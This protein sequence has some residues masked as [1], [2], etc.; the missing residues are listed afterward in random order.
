MTIM[1]EAGRCATIAGAHCLLMIPDS[2]LVF[3]NNAVIIARII[4]SLFNYSIYHHIAICGLPLPPSKIFS[5]AVL[6]STY[7]NDYHFAA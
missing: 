3:N 2:P 1:S 5:V 6:E 7:A 4:H